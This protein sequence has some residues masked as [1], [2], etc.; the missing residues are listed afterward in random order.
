MTRHRATDSSTA[1]HGFASWSAGRFA[2]GTLGLAMIGLVAIQGFHLFRI[3]AL[4]SVAPVCR[5]ETD[6]RVVALSFD[7]GPSRTQTPRVLALLERYDAVATFFVVGERVNEAPDLVRAEVRAG[8]EIGDHT[9]SHPQLQSATS[10]EL[11][12]EIA[13]TQERLRVEGIDPSLFR[14]PY[15]MIDAPQLRLVRAGN[16]LPVHWSLPLDHYVDG[17]GLDPKAAAAAII[18]DLTPG[19]IVLA[20]DADDG[21]ISRN[22]AIATLG[23]LLPALHEAGY[24]T[25]TISDLLEA[26]NPVGAIPRPWFWQSGFSCPD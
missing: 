3:R 15:G 19:A 25:V 10:G 13:R 17:R 12:G 16:L 4:R 5:V 1:G 11:L 20:H 6:D 24:R 18:Q 2:V 21:G 26:G 9:W 22:A 14:A 23:Y 8:M 7:D